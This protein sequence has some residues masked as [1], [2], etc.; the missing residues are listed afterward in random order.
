MKGSGKG[1]GLGGERERGLGIRKRK[2]KWSGDWMGRRKDCWGL[3]REKKKGWRLD[4]ETE[5]LLGTG[6]GWED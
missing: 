1:D 3:E 2:E 4:G 5:R 6:K